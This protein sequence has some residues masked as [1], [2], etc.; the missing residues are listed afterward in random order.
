MNE[1]ATQNVQQPQSKQD[2]I[3]D[4]INILAVNNLTISD[5]KDILY[6]TSKAICKQPVNPHCQTKQFPN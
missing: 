3:N 5:S 2:I 6:E 4:I 1:T